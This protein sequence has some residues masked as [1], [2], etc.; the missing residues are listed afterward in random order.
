MGLRGFCI[1]GMA[2]C[3]QMAREKVDKGESLDYTMGR[4]GDAPRAAPSGAAPG[5]GL[6]TQT[7]QARQAAVSFGGKG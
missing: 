6:F 1:P 5:N 2:L 4:K 7:V 3:G